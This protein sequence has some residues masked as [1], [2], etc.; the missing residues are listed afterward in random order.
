MCRRSSPKITLTSALSLGHDKVSDEIFSSPKVK[1]L[2]NET[3][4]L[5]VG[6]W[7]CYGPDLFI[8]TI[9]VNSAMR[10]GFKTEINL[11]KYHRRVVIRAQE[12]WRIKCG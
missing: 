10:Q 1:A 3:P 8:T 5:R 4:A 7:R 6:R 11:T 12:R 9:G 2:R